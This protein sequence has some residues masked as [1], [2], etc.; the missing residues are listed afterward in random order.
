MPSYVFPKKNTEFIFITGLVSQ[1]NTKIFQANPTLA[2]GDAK[3]SVDYDTTPDNLATLP[4]ALGTTKLVKV[5]LSTSEMNGENIAVILSDA[6]G[7]E[8]CD[9]IINIQTTARQVDDLAYPATS[10]R[11]LLVNAT[12]AVPVSGF[13]T[14]AKGEINVEVLDVMTVDTFAEP[15]GVPAST[16]TL[17]GKLGR[18]YESLRNKATV[19]TPGG[20][21][22]F[23]NDAGTATWK[24]VVTDAGG[25]Y[26]EDK[27]AAP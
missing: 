8:W 23:Y 26:T 10:G 19:S 2:S 11:S 3:V 25:V 5:T 1:A 22:T 15:T 18:V 24:K 7:D 9:Q 16:T 27:A 21:K 6:A 12:G 13:E 14:A 4:A 20:N 17:A